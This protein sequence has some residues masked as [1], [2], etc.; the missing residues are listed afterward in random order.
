MVDAKINVHYTCQ[1]C[2]QPLR[3]DPAFNNLSEQTI[4]ELSGNY[5]L[6][7]FILFVILK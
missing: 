2:M 3:L 5:K 1:R 7:N 6:L 4:A